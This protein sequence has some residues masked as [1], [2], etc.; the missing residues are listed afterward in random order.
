MVG[1]GYWSHILDDDAELQIVTQDGAM[2]IP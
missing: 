1:L 2:P